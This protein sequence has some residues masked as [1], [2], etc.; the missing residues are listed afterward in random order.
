M[1]FAQKGPGRGGSGETATGCASKSEGL[2]WVLESFE[3]WPDEATVAWHPWSRRVEARH[4]YSIPNS[5]CP[6]W[7]RKLFP[8]KAGLERELYSYHVRSILSRFT[9]HRVDP[10][11]LLNIKA[12]EWNSLE[13]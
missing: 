8:C 6:S 3:L 13:V 10:N 11:A 2:F 5:H 4:S 7:L 9:H 12:I 1:V